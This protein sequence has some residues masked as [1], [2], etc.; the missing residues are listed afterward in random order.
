MRYLSVCS[1]IEAVSVAWQDMDW[2]PAA[3][4]ETDPHASSV[5][6]H[7]FP[8]VQN[9]GDF[10][11][12]QEHEYGTIDL[13]VGG[14]PCQAFSIAGKRTGVDDPRGNLTLE[15]IRLV[16]RV[17]P[18]WFLWE[19]VPGVL[20]IDDGRTF[21][22]FLHE[23]GELGYGTAYRILD[24]QYVRTPGFP[25]ALPQ[26]RRRVF[27]VGCAGTRWRASAAVLFDSRSLSGDPPPSRKKGET[28]SA[29]LVSHIGTGG[30]EGYRFCVV[31]TR[32]SPITSTD[33]SLPLE[34]QSNQAVVSAAIT[35]KWAKGNGGPSGD[36][37]QNLVVNNGKL[38]KFT[39]LECERLQGFPD[40]WTRVL[41]NGKKMS[42]SARYRM[43]GNAM[44]VNVME[45]IG[46]RMEYVNRIL[47]KKKP[48]NHE[49]LPGF[50][51]S[52]PNRSMT[53]RA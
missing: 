13:V 23:M 9:H 20:S 18:R 26:R 4:A 52:S 48:G 44:S 50:L 6:A 42:N 41:H 1:G 38:R 12:I 21:G 47:P 43:L 7:H 36:E 25:R 53:N 22:T 27:V 2:Q 29:T 10:T 45:W 15:F 24:T 17:R 11:T 8:D 28:C 31:H 14:T 37:C 40:E 19:N 46:R 35:S 30:D 33:V 51:N 5:L 34:V 32:Q 49:E 3:F 39:P 16:A